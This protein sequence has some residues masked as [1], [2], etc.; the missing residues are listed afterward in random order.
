MGFHSEVR[1]LIDRRLADTEN[2][3]VPITE[4]WSQFDPVA[5][6]SARAS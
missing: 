4:M 2:P 1:E 3:P 6:E 5:W